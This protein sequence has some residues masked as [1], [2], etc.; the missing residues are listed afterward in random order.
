M[1]GCAPAIPQLLDQIERFFISATQIMRVWRYRIYLLYTYIP[2]FGGNNLL[3]APR[4]R[5]DAL[6]WL[7]AITSPI[8]APHNLAASLP[9]ARACE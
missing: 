9:A 1:N 7:T 6:A 3:T 4:F 8:A 5:A 2:I